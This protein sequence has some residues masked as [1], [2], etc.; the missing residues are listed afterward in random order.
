[1]KCDSS[2]EV[3]CHKKLVEAGLAYDF[4]PKSFVLLNGF[5]S[6]PVSLEPDERI[7]KLLSLK[8]EKI[9]PITYKIDFADPKLRWMIETKGYAR[10]EFAIRWKL[11]KYR[12]SQDGIR[13]TLFLPK[14]HPQVDNAIRLILEMK[15]D[16]HMSAESPTLF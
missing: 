1:V 14:D 2:L 5:T 8:T 3:Y 9:Q 16:K 13:T 15:L 12:L 4:H 11:F 10:S 7:G 6:L